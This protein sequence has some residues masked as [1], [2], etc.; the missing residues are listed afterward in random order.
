MPQTT[1]LKRG[2]GRPA[3]QSPNFTASPATLSYNIIRL[4]QLKRTRDD[5][6]FRA[7]AGIG[8]SQAIILGPLHQTPSA[9][10]GQLAR[11]MLVT[12]QSIAPQ[13]DE[14]ESLGLVRKGG[15]KRRGEANLITITPEG[16]RKYPAIEAVRAH[17]DGEVRS[18]LSEA[19]AALFNDWLLRLL[20]TYSALAEMPVPPTQS[21]V[22]HLEKPREKQNRQRKSS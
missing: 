14:L 2:R 15:R 22:Q 11:A 19:E 3:A 4:A 20:G 1:K 17:A 8:L 5:A 7:E 13:I 6:M 12:P 21:R 16:H 18:C 9:S 10:A